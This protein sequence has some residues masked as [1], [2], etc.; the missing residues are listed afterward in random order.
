MFFNRKRV[1]GRKNAFY[2]RR[3]CAES[4][5]ALLDDEKLCNIFLE[6]FITK[7]DSRRLKMSWIF[8]KFKKTFHSF[9]ISEKGF[10]CLCNNLIDLAICDDF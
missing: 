5:F 4:L 1:S 9:H 6:I 10:K 3:W 2:V 7:E 8:K